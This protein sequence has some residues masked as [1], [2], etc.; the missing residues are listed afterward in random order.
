ME[1]STA[2]CILLTIGALVVGMGI[3]QSIEREQV[4]PHCGRERSR[5]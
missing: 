5:H 1:P 4:C 3:G 2:L